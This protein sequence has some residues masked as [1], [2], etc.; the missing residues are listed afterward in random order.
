MPNQEMRQ[1]FFTPVWAAVLMGMAGI[2]IA[3]LASMLG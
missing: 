1:G 2:L 3:L